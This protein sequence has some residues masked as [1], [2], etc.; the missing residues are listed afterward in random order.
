M[1]KFDEDTMEALFYYVHDK[2]HLYQSDAARFMKKVISKAPSR[3]KTLYRGISSKEVYQFE[4]KAIGDICEVKYPISFSEDEKVSLEFAKGS[5]HMLVLNDAVGFNYGKFMEAEYL[6]IKKEDPKQFKQEGII[7]VLELVRDEKEWFVDSGNF[8][9]TKV[10]KKNG[11]TYTYLIQTKAKSSAPTK[12]SIDKSKFTPSIKD[13]YDILENSYNGRIN[14]KTGNFE[15]MIGK[16]QIIIYPN[17]YVRI[18]R[19]GGQLSVIAKPDPDY[20]G[21]EPHKIQSRAFENALNYIW[22]NKNKLQ[23]HIVKLINKIK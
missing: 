22:K 20:Y 1:A 23:E 3:F 16:N 13:A 6:R 17:G 2:E 15:M 19:N 14:Q 8:E 7:D 5:K 10:E 12:L 11:L 4:S 21:S 18:S 9:V